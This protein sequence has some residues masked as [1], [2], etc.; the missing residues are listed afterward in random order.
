MAIS[1]RMNNTNNNNTLA[2]SQHMLEPTSISSMLSKKETPLQSFLRNKGVVRSASSSSYIATMSGGR[3]PVR[4]RNSM[5]P[6]TTVV[7]SNHMMDTATNSRTAA[8]SSELRQEILSTDIARSKA[9]GYYGY[10][11]E[12]ITAL[13]DTRMLTPTMAQQH[14]GGRRRVMR[15]NSCN[16]TI[17]RTYSPPSGCYASA[18]IVSRSHSNDHIGIPK[19][20]RTSIGAGTA[21]VQNRRL[22]RSRSSNS[23]HTNEKLHTKGGSSSTQYNRRGSLGSKGSNDSCGSSALYPTK[24]KRRG[25]GS[26]MFGGSSSNGAKYKLGGVGGGGG[27][28]STIPYLI[29]TH[30]KLSPPAVVSNTNTQYHS[31]GAAAAQ[32]N[33][34]QIVSC[35]QNDG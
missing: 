13:N 33:A 5:G 16:N 18:G 12:T 20:R 21:K 9:D 32:A 1:S 15:R 7:G 6:M 31:A 14:K 34:N 27:T 17:G 19:Q 29:T 35:Q 30:K 4:R 2:Q 24:A 23:G 3:V 26:H 25:S 8:S 10:G 11:E 22:S 28:A